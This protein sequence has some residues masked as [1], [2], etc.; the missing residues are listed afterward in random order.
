[1]YFSYVYEI[2]VEKSLDEYKDVWIWS[3]KAVLNP[4]S[5]AIMNLLVFAFI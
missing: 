5:V 1:M 4:F 2:Y 3:L